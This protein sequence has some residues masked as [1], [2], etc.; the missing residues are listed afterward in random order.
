[1]YQIKIRDTILTA[2][3]GENLLSVLRQNGLAPDTPCGGNGKC[4]KCRMM[5]N[6]REV[7]ACQY[8]VN[9]DITVEPH[10]KD[11]TRILTTGTD[12]SVPLDPV[13]AGHP[14][15]NCGKTGKG[16]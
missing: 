3:A 14:A 7:L 9:S 6:G 4:G 16:H 8:E 13:Q 1:M 10:Q 2:G 5:V 12:V 15:A 11:R